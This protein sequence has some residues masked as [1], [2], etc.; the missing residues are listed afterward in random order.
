MKW[1]SA[2]ASDAAGGHGVFAPSVQPL[3]P[4]SV[5]AGPATT[6]RVARDDNFD[7]R[8]AI[9]AGG[10]SGTVLVIAGGA[11]SRAACMGG[12]VARD[13]TASGIIAVVTDAPVRDSSEIARVGLRV[14]SR[15]VTPL[16]P[17]KVGG[18]DLGRRVEL[19]GATVAPGDWVIADDDGVVVWPHERLDE[20]NTRAAD[21]ERAELRLV[22]RRK[23]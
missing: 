7:L 8:R 19:A 16:K 14:W 3:R 20:L 21:L 17:N 6:V 13:L 23:S 2:L 22:R 1:S 11:A 10:L 4:G 12:K 5:V 18:G 15:G 9:D